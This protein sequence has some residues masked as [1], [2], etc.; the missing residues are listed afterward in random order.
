MLMYHMA[1]RNVHDV[2]L[3]VLI[4]VVHHNIKHVSEELESVFN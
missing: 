2:L 3:L 4:L 1:K